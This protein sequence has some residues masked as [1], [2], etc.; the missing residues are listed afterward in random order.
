M[1]NGNSNLAVEKQITRVLRFLA[2]GPARIEQ[3]A[4]KELLVLT[5]AEKGSIAIPEA[6]CRQLVSAGLVVRLGRQ[7]SAEPS[8]QSRLRR[9]GAGQ[10]AYL[11]QHGE[12]GEGTIST[13][14]GIEQVTVNHS[15]SPLGRLARLKT[16][17]GSNFLEVWELCAGERLRADF[18]RGQ[19]E[20]RLGINW[21]ATSGNGCKRGSGGSADLTE[22]AMSA[23]HR[24]ASALDAVGPELSGILVDVCCF[25]KGLSE[26]ER[27]RSW[28]VRSA[29]IVLKTALA[30]LAR[31]YEPDACVAAPQSATRHWGAPGYRPS[32]QATNVPD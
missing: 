19:M 18:S 8:G 28:P 2:G 14:A 25:L 5:N 20:P 30:A 1:S 32:L 22:A 23:R 15:E 3:G 13:D 16:G 11:R 10:T 27:E 12:I 31:H 4:R 26:I 21:D 6:I 24:V 29:K 9:N 7:L 17:S